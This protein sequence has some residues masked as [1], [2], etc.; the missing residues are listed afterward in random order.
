MKYIIQAGS[1]YQTDN[2][3]PGVKLAYLESPY[4]PVRKTILSPDG[5][6]KL[7][8]DIQTSGSSGKIRERCY[9]LKDPLDQVILSGTPGPAGHITFNA[10]RIDHVK[11]DMDHKAYVLTM[12]NSQ[13]YRLVDED[14]RKAA[15]ILHNGT[16]G[17]WKIE[18]EPLFSPY[19][20]MGLY[21]FCRYLD[22]ENEFITV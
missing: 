9:T 15:Q 3:R 14:D 1:L 4:Y 19:A 8:A 16:E 6:V 18:T 12:K 11:I 7:Y 17:G 21:I 20:L 13:E 10:P 2:G 22:K 5:R